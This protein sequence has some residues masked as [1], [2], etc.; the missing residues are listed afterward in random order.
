MHGCRT[1]QHV[2]QEDPWAGVGRRHGPRKFSTR[3]PGWPPPSHLPSL[4]IRCYI[5]ASG[6]S[7]Q[8]IAT[9][10]SGV[11]GSPQSALSA[12]L[13]VLVGRGLAAPA[14]RILGVFLA[15]RVGSRLG[16]ANTEPQFLQLCF[17]HTA[18]L[19]PRL[20]RGGDLRRRLEM[21]STFESVR[22]V[23][24]GMDVTF[25]AAAYNYNMVRM[26]NLVAAVLKGKHEA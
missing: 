4:T 14:T 24:S 6:P 26:R 23:S 7:R 9:L 16:L 11:V 19:R 10:A 2:R 12:S 13:S 22:L 3:A 18:H 5:L 8:V 15:P 17:R 25:A 21:N 1:I 20:W